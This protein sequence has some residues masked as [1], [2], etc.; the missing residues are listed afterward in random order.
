VHNKI[1]ICVIVVGR[2]N[3]SI[4][5]DYICRI[6]FVPYSVI[7]NVYIDPGNVAA[8]MAE[9]Q[10]ERERKKRI[11]V[12]KVCVCARARACVRA[13]VRPP[14][15]NLHQLKPSKNDAKC[16]NRNQ[17]KSQTFN[18][19]SVPRQSQLAVARYGL[20]TAMYRKRYHQAV[21]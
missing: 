19:L 3:I 15:Q 9:K 18:E 17:L 5:Y 7:R 13:C 20:S 4:C 8:S 11:L 1:Q 16:N 21:L 2:S 12:N 6:L 14:Q 10:M